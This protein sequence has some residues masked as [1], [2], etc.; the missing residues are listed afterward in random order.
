LHDVE[1]G[2]KAVIIQQI[3]M[4]LAPPT[5]LSLPATSVHLGSKWVLAH[6]DDGLIVVKDATRWRL[7]HAT[8]H[9]ILD[10]IEKGQ[11]LLTYPKICST[12]RAKLD[13]EATKQGGT[14]LTGCYCQQ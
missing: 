10:P 9:H 5:M 1:K 8:C 2:L 7:H 6:R 4:F 11:S 12:S 14:I 3:S 13:I